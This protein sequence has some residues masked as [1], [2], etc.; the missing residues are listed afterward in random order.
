MAGNTSPPEQ[1]QIRPAPHA[2]TTDWLRDGWAGSAPLPA[3]KI[4]H[5][6][7]YQ[8]AWIPTARALAILNAGGAISLVVTMGDHGPEMS[9]EAMAVRLTSDATGG[10]RHGR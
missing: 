2:G 4:P 5:V 8:T 6:L 1:A 3:T 10:A 7:G 9:M